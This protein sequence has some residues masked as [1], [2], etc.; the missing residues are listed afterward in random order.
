VSWLPAASLCDSAAGY[1][2]SGIDFYFVLPT[3]ATLPSGWDVAVGAGKGFGSKLW[4]KGVGL[5]TGTVSTIVSLGQYCMSHARTN[6]CLAAVVDAC[7]AGDVT[8]VGEPRHRA[9]ADRP[10][11]AAGRHADRVF[12]RGEVSEPVG[13]DRIATIARSRA[14]EELPD[15]LIREARAANGGD[16]A[17]AAVARWPAAIGAALI[18]AFGSR[19]LAAV[20]L[21]PANGDAL[22]QG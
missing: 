19:S 20:S 9:D 3:R 8:A 11:P 13:V 15:A 21:S 14:V 6:S 10:R 22:T 1:S 17:T 16:D 4:Q 18:S 7:V 12:R 2:Y 5:D